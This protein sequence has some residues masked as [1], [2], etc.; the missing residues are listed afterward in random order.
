ML[1]ELVPSTDPILKQST[2]SFDFENPPMDPIDLADEMRY[3]LCNH[4]GIGLSAPQ[5]GY[6]YSVF[7]VGNPEVESS[8]LVFFNPKIV[9]YSDTIV[10]MEEGCLSFPGMVLKIKRPDEVRMRYTG[11]GGM[12]KTDKFGGMTARVIQHE[13]DHLQG[14]TFDS[15]VSSFHLDKAKKK[16]KIM[17]RRMKYVA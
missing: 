11:A 16:R 14:I 6:N 17:N 1:K 3:N 5:I 15:K 8:V 9:H 10:T 7:A 13:Y 4:K 2:V 12:T